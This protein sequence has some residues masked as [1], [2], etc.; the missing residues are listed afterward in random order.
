[1]LFGFF[2]LE[3]VFNIRDRFTKNLYDFW[4]KL[5]PGA[6]TQLFIS[7]FYGGG[8]TVGALG[9]HRIVSI[10][11][12]QNSGEWRNVSAGNT[13]GIAGAV[14]MFVMLEDGLADLFQMRDIMKNFLILAGSRIS[15]IW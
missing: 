7:L 6:S 8:R 5:V 1:M 4:I 15:A 10:S 14:K 13:V 2:P 11:Y 3:N 9:Y 12:T